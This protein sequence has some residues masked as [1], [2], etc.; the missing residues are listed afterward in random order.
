SDDFF[1][2][3]SPCQR[4]PP[5][6]RNAGGFVTVALAQNAHRKRTGG[7]DIGRVVQQ[8][9][10]LLRKVRPAAVR[11]TL[12]SAR[13]VESNDAR[14]QER[15]LPPRVKSTTILVRSLAGFVSAR[16]KIQVLPVTVGLIRFRARAADAWIEQA[17]E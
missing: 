15:A 11:G 10:R 14:M 4:L 3:R 6:P 2:A 9:Q 8:H 1:G 12:L 16:R 5:S 7:F 13:R 17:G